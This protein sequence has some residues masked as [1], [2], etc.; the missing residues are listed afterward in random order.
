MILPE[1]LKTKEAPQQSKA[2]QLRLSFGS[3]SSLI[4][5]FHGIN[6]DYL[7]FQLAIVIPRIA[8]NIRPDSPNNAMEIL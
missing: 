2:I 6:G 1:I 5:S 7:A 4:P 8:K 3:L